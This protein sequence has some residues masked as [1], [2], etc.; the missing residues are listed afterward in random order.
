MFLTTGPPPSRSYD[1]YV[2]GAGPA[3]ITLALALA[4]GDRTVLLFESGTATEAREDLP[5][6]IN[7]GHF[8]DGW[9]DQ[10]S[11]PCQRL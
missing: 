5:N 3:G 11:G 10:H 7:Y 4:Q 9:W 6:A 8:R 2:I 1:Y